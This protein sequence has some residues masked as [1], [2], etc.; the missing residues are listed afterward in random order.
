M[1]CTGTVYPELKP[2]SGGKPPPTPIVV[3]ICV[4]S[5]LYLFAP[6][7]Q[8]QGLVGQLDLTGTGVQGMGAGARPMGTGMVRAGG[9]TVHGDGENWK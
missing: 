7:G 6:E 5:V 3:D 9:Q 8:Y 4:P 2:A 1:D